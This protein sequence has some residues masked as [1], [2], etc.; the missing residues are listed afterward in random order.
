MFDLAQR[1]RSAG[2]VLPAHKRSFQVF[3]SGNPTLGEDAFKSLVRTRGDQ[4]MTVQGT[5]N[6]TGISILILM[7][8]AALTWNGAFSFL[9]LKPL[10]YGS[11]ICGFGVA[12]ATVFKKEWAPLTTPI[13]AALEGI[14]LGVVSVAFNY[15]YPGIALNAFALTV[16]TLAALLLAYRTGVIRSSENFTRGVVAATGGVALVYGLSILLGFFGIEI[17]L[18]HGSGLV[19]IGFSLVVVVLASLNLVLDFAFIERGAAA[20]APKYMEWYGAFGLLVTLVWLYLELLRL[21]SKL[22]DRRR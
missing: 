5:V 16:G 6:K 14:V 19:G 17:P 20:G 4:A 11:M 21:L 22:Q 13:Y 9:P 8:T 12:M 2:A 7:A 1:N 3:R 15:Q 18:I 10:L